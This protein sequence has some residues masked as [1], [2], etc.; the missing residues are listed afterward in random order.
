MVQK[1]VLS[2]VVVVG[3]LYDLHFLLE[4]RVRLL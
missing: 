1:D 3:P 4:L 2:I